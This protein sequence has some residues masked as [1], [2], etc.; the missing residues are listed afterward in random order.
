MNR[1]RFPNLQIRCVEPNSVFPS[2]R[3]RFGPAVAVVLVTCA[4]L[5]ALHAGL[6][7]TSRSPAAIAQDEA[8]ATDAPF[9]DTVL[10][11]HKNGELTIEVDGKTHS[12]APSEIRQAAP[13]L[14]A[15]HE[16]IAIRMEDWKQFGP[17]GSSIMANLYDYGVRKVTLD[18]ESEGKR[19][20]LTRELRPPSISQRIDGHDIARRTEALSELD[21]MFQS[22]NSLG[23]MNILLSVRNARFDRE[24]YLPFVRESLQSQN[25][26]VIGAAI[27]TIG[28]VGGDASDIPAVLKHLQHDR[29]SVRARIS[30]AL[31]S[32]DPLGKSPEVG[33]AI[34]ELLSDSN[35]A[36]RDATI[37]SLWGN[38]TTPGVE[39]KL[40]ELSKGESRGGS[41]EAD[42]TV[43]Y[44]LSTRPLVRKPVAARLIEIIN[45]DAIYSDRSVWGI[46]HHSADD[47]ARPIVV[48]AL[49][50]VINSRVDGYA[51]DNAM[52]GL[53]THGGAAASAKL[54]A[55][56]ADP[57][58]S[59]KARQRAV[60]L[61]PGSLRTD[62]AK[63]VA[64]SPSREVPTELWQQIL[65]PRDAVLR[66]EALGKVRTLLQDATTAK[67]GLDALIRSADAVAD[68]TSCVELARP[69]LKSEDHEVRARAVSFFG[70]VET[71]GL[72]AADLAAYCDDASPLVRTAAI[73]TLLHVDPKCLQPETRTQIE[74]LLNDSNTSVVTG[75]LHA[76]WGHPTT[77]EAE[78]SLIN[79]T[80]HADF[81]KDAVYYA[82]TTR[83]LIRKPVAERLLDLAFHSNDHRGRAIWG[84]THNQVSDDARDLVVSSLIKI[85][86]STVD[87]YDRN[88]A[89]WGLGR[90]GGPT[91][92]KELQR[93]AADPDESAEVKRKARDSLDSPSG[94]PDGADDI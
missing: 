61:L 64:A 22:G 89:I 55:I 91:A 33:P 65:Q 87:G 72:S 25:D 73:E 10:L 12:I 56:A 54:Q 68:R 86:S 29:A 6:A 76:L 13:R 49:I 18:I 75:T 31:C 14:L 50:D 19:E 35:R 46:S 58:E 20:R 52:F 67:D 57:N 2:C 71:E 30:T 11:F 34:E 23:G 51:R 90:I 9:P 84:L 88:N 66:A 5:P 8:A 36:V 93:L 24:K 32:L 45:A 92:K 26:N 42:I 48:Q 38:V 77:A 7:E 59:V 1:R 62:S 80:Y 69:L 53:R 81:E 44:A 83:P 41:G 17:G 74:K 16:H 28:I 3:L 27:S 85:I 47:E 39:A 37:R 4:C 94:M 78:T 82:L 43:Y 63:V 21:Q 70:L 40:I 60:Q 79:L 15:G